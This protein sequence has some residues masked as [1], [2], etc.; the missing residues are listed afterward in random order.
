[1][2]IGLI[3]AGFV[4]QAVMKEL[5]ARGHAVTLLVRSPEK[6]H[7]PA[8]VTVLKVN[9]QDAEAVAYAVKGLD[10][11]IS[12]YNAGWANPD[13]YADFLK[14]SRAIQAGVKAADGPRLIVVGGAGSLFVAPGQQLVDQ[15]AFPAEYKAGATAAR[16]YLNELRKEEKLD[17]T[18]FSPAIEMHPG[19]SGVRK[20]EYRT[21][22]E[23]PVFDANGRS[24]LSVEDLA[25]AVVD[26]AENH[27]YSRQRFTAA[28]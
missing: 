26:E 4:G 9:A 22:L 12:A 25:V 21:D 2:K 27:R 20:G 10:V 5:T 1:M 7:A 11:V 14:G 15:P 17:W 18:F 16:D 13:L 19:T 8:G 6:A 24:V 28:Y 23:S 3:G